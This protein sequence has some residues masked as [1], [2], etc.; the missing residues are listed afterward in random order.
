MQEQNIIIVEDDFSLLDEYIHT[1]GICNILL[2]CGNSIKKLNISHYF[3]QLNQQQ[4]IRVVRFSDFTPNP[5]YESVVKGVELFRSE[6]CD[7]IIAIGGG[8]AIDVAKCIKLFAN[9]LPDTNYLNQII[10]QNDIPFAVMPTTAGT[11]SEATQF[12]VIYFKGEKQSVTHVNCIPDTVLFDKKVLHHLPMYHKKATMLDALCHAIE[13]YWSV[14]ATEESRS[15]ATA[16]L[17]LIMSNME[18]YLSGNESV[19][20]NMLKAAYLAGKAIN[21]AKTTAGH[22]MSYKL[23]SLYKIAHG[24]AVAVCI[25]KV[26]NYMEDKGSERLR[27][28]LK[29]LAKLMNCNTSMEAVCFLETLVD[30]LQLTFIESVTENDIDILVDSV[31]VERLKNTPITLDKEALRNLYIKILY[32]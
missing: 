6:R 13:S 14:H 1:V 31:N 7:A 26:W 10:T 21:I 8:S 5:S 27:Q 2:V 24:H 30:R 28:Q 25:P 16:A 32:E 20:A 15:Y 11:G 12:A 18:Q 29:E 3:E 19:Y 22:A 4:G 9:M 23:T 17:S